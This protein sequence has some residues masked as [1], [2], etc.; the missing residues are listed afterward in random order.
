MTKQKVK[1]KKSAGLL[2]QWFKTQFSSS[3][4]NGRLQIGY[5]SQGS[6]AVLPMF[7]CERDK[8]AVFLSESMVFHP[9]VDYYITA[10]TVSG[11]KRRGEQ[12]FSLENI[13]IDI[14]C[15]EE[16]FTREEVLNDKID[17]I[18]WL[19]ENNTDLPAPNTVVRTGR[20]IQLWWAIVPCH[21]KCKPYYDEVKDN[22]ILELMSILTET[23]EL[24][25][26]SVDRT[27]SSN[28]VGYYRIPNTYNTKVNRLVLCEV[29]EDRKPYVLQELVALV[30]SWDHHDNDVKTYERT[31]LAKT[32]YSVAELSLLKNFHTL[33]FFRSRQLIQLR[34]IR[35]RGV[36]KEERNNFCFLMFNTLL[37]AF[38]EEKTMEKL[39]LFNHGF[40]VPLTKEEIENVICTAKKKNGYKYSNQKIIEFLNI[41]PEEQEQ[42][43]LYGGK[44]KSLT[45]ISSHPSRKASAGL[46]KESRNQSIQNLAETGKTIKEIA[47]ELGL[48]PPTVSKVLRTQGGSLAE[49]LQKKI[50]DMASSGIHSKEIAHHCHC[51][52]RTVQRNLSMA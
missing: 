3:A 26:F 24:D 41:N 39:Y 30:K 51:S 37:P 35:N 48:S 1:E 17:R 43:G 46:M 45:G 18:L 9:S 4:F 7:T 36:G 5:R 21:A 29:K 49:R 16:P 52:L 11:V 23:E 44:F 38:G 6:S 19:M 10:N 42:I 20:G 22:F 25:C 34:Q 50:K 32:E 33:G 12:L 27:A 28:P 2:Q 47:L 15:H 31:P 13:V 14:D 40:K 8:L